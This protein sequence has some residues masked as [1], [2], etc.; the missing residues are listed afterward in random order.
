MLTVQV[1]FDC[2]HTATANVD[3]SPVAGADVARDVSAAAEQ[4]RC[5]EPGCGGRYYVT[6]P[7]PGHPDYEAHLGR[8]GVDDLGV[9]LVAD[10]ALQ[11]QDAPA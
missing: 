10:V 2:S 1:V 4:L 6:A 5:T 9:D 11:P 8:V 7:A 3:V